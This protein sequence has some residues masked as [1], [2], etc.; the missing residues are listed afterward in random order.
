MGTLVEQSSPVKASR[1]S[2]RSSNDKPNYNINSKFE[3]LEE[4]IQLLNETTDSKLS[5]S[6]KDS[7]KSKL[8]SRN[9]PCPASKKSKTKPTATVIDL[10]DESD[11]DDI[12]IDDDVN[13]FGGMDE[14]PCFDEPVDYDDHPQETTFNEF[15][16]NDADNESWK[17]WI[18]SRIWESHTKSSKLVEVVSIEEMSIEQNAS[19]S[20][21]K[22][23]QEAKSLIIRADPADP[24]DFQAWKEWT[25]SKIWDHHQPKATIDRIAE[26]EAPTIVPSQITMG[27]PQ[28][29]T[30]SSTRKRNKSTDIASANKDI[31]DKKLQEEVQS[32]E[33]EITFSHF[34]EV[35]GNTNNNTEDECNIFL[36]LTSYGKSYPDDISCPL[37]DVKIVEM[38]AKLAYQEASV[39]AK[40]THDELFSTEKILALNS[41]E[42]MEWKDVIFSLIWSHTDFAKTVNTDL[43]ETS[44]NSQEFVSAGQCKEKD[45]AN[46]EIHDKTTVESNLDN[47]RE[48]EKEKPE[49]IKNAPQKSIT[50]DQLSLK[51]NVKEIAEEIIFDYD[52]LSQSKERVF[53]LI[54][55]RFMGNK[56]LGMEQPTKNN[57]NSQ[58][59]FD[60]D[61]EPL[62]KRSRRSSINS[63]PGKVGNNKTK[64][65]KTTS[66]KSRRISDSLNNNVS[67]IKQKNEDKSITIDKP[68]LR[69]AGPASKMNALSSK[70]EVLTKRPGPAS[71]RSSRSRA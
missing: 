54:W 10:D 67:P 1:T 28:L 69:K 61:D 71:R 51:N 17:D 27:E 36:P 30:R 34:D 7:S 29:Q 15:V 42:L 57:K 31:I 9:K 46:K 38:N 64:E 70:T 47:L 59:A 56:S 16:Q 12:I 48:T 66:E 43:K 19:E 55:S 65:S 58:R 20:V 33:K 18:F 25:L 13:S 6:K 41:S 2:R 22:S 3:D 68:S 63:N 45:G 52:N 23:L 37:T 62:S 40:D 49:P 60:C 44:K 21:E 39:S 32:F 11:D 24:T 35:D 8:G 14:V 5:R 53:D 50:I 26:P 4:E